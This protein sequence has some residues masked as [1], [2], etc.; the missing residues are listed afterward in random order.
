MGEIQE[1]ISNVSANGDKMWI[2]L[3]KHLNNVIILFGKFEDSK[4]NG[5]MSGHNFSRIL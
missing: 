5:E 3:S 2:D 1:I 4:Q